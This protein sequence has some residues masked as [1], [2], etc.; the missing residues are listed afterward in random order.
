MLQALQDQINDDKAKGYVP[1]CIIGNA[2]TV[3]TG[4][5]DPLDTLLKIAAG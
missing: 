3:N 1:F 2:G 4:A 5:I